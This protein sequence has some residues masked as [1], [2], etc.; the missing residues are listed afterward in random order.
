MSKRYYLAVYTGT[1]M[2]MLLLLWGASYLLGR[3]GWFHWTTLPAVITSGGE[4][5]LG[6]GTLAD[7]NERAGNQVKSKSHKP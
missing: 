7:L 5:A 2:A 1:I 3:F 4:I 6:L